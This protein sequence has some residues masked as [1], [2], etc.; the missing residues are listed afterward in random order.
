MWI[1]AELAIVI[2]M[3]II[4]AFELIRAVIWEIQDMIE[5]Y[6]GERRNVYR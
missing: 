5:D 4:T 3:C 6:K 2:I 1:Y